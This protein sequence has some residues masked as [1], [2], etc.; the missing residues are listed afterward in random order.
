MHHLAQLST[1]ATVPED[2]RKLSPDIR[3]LAAGLRFPEGPVSM[4][5]GSVLVV[6]MAGG[7]LQKC[8]AIAA[9]RIPPEL[10]E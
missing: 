6:E 4:A 9:D 10:D 2:M 3:V 7:T 1:R 5:D 8:C